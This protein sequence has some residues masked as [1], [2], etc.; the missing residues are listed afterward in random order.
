MPSATP[1]LS[2]VI[3]TLNRSEFIEPVVRSI[4]D[5]CPETQIV[6]SDNSTTDALRGKFASAIN[7][8]RITYA[9]H[10][11][12]ISGVENFERAWQMA[13]GEYLLFI[14]DDDT[15]G[16]DIEA[17]CRWAQAENIDALVSYR[18][19]FIAN[20]FWPGVKSRWFGD[21]YS[22]TLFINRFTQKAWPIDGRKQI[23]AICERP[24]A[25][26]GALPRAYHGV[27]SRE[28]AE[29]IS[30]RYGGLFGGVSPDIYSATLISFEARKAYVVD[31]P[32][33]IPGAS[34]VS[35]AGQGAARQDS[36]DINA[37][38]HIRR[39][40][41]ALVWDDRIPKFYS[42]ITVWAYSLQKALDKLEAHPREIN[43][44]GL[45]LKCA[46]RYPSHIALIRRSFAL[47]RR[48]AHWLSLARQC[49]VSMTI[50]S[51]LFIYR[52]WSR[53]GPIRP[54]E[55]RPLN[56]IDQA[57]NLL[58]DHVRG[59]PAKADARPWASDKTLS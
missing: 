39:F 21:K 58:A 7:A 12:P 33:V 56:D 43:F 45:Y 30:Q 51:A 23:A 53:F 25:G 1:I 5:N 10:D 3:P 41:S 4:L 31:H 47:W 15:V 49:I 37:F 14:G 6:I 46:V 28:L 34:P 29:R 2:V 54:R 27:I 52:Q 9:F 13:R 50:E 18:T 35:T 36:G 16:P 22:A 26:L 20:Y 42:P 57:Y 55:I 24:G 40:G 48:D 19:K 44:P 17:I 32:F 11:Q 8:G 38:D 59:L